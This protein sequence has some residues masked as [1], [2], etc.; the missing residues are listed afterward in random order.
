MHAFYN[1]RTANVQAADFKAGGAST[2]NDVRHSD[3]PCLNILHID[4]YRG[5]DLGRVILNRVHRL[6]HFAQQHLVALG[7]RRR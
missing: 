1:N 4:A 3:R 7:S 2:G 5:S 6:F